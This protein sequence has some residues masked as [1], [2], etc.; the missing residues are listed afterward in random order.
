MIFID[1]TA[2]NTG[3]RRSTHRFKHD[4]GIAEFSTLV[5][6]AASCRCR[7]PRRV[8]PREEGR[9]RPSWA[10]AGAGSGPRRPRTCQELRQQ[11]PHRPT[12]APTSSRPARGDRQGGAQ[13]HRDPRPRAQG[14]DADRR[15]HPRGRRRGAVSVRPRPAVPGPDQEPPQQPRGRGAGR[16]RGAAGARAVA[17][18]T[19]GP[20]PRPSSR[21][22]ILAARA[23]EASRGGEQQVTARPRSATGSTCRAS[24]PTARR[25][26]P[27]ES[28]LFIVE[29]DSAGGS[30][31]QGRDRR[32]Q[33]ILPLRG[34]VLNAEQA[35]LAKVLE[36][37]ELQDI[38]SALGCGIG[39]D[40]D[41]ASCATARSDPADGRRQRRPPH[42]D[43]AAH[44]L[45]PA[46]AQA[47]RAGHVYLAQPPLYR[48]DIGKET[49]W[50]LDDRRASRILKRSK[51]NAKHHPVQREAELISR[52]K[53]LGEMLQAHHRADLKY[54]RAVTQAARR[55]YGARS[56]RC[57]AAGG[58]C[59]ARTDRCAGP[60][61]CS[62][63]GR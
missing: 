21:A 34:K 29:G 24:W 27:S 35:S 10:R 2:K 47:D 25:P 43:A 62:A 53:G 28:E 38:V 56:I 41:A 11:H 59:A 7:R 39:P 18:T 48:I 6:P 54:R 57:R 63:P 19:T 4:K 13:L 55:A 26:T 15:G 60:R 20:P 42:R 50:A 58:S 16:G 3:Q 30:A 1:E 8:L 33:A 12:A 61:G 37:K 46:H 17:A 32:T 49:F 44:V 31:K 52:F 51:G 14:R 36:N 23:R 22:S 5:R 9:R 45:L 40:F